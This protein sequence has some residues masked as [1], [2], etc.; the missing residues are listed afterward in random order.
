MHAPASSPTDGNQHWFSIETKHLSGFGFHLRP[1]IPLVAFSP[2]R[3]PVKSQP[4]Q[5]QSPPPR[6]LSLDNIPQCG[7]LES[8]LSARGVPDLSLPSLRIAHLTQGPATPETEA[9][10]NLLCVAAASVLYFI[11]VRSHRAAYT[12]PDTLLRVLERQHFEWCHSRC[13]CEFNL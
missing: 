11:S 2:L 9:T 13:R 7:I 4:R 1:K 12:A 3:N 6:H 5:A 10:A 8:G